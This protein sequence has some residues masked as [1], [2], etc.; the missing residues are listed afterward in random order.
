M[1]KFKF[2]NS[3]QAIPEDRDGNLPAQFTITAA[4][5]TDIWAKPPSTTRFNAP[6]LCQS[7]PLASFKRARLSFNANWKDQYDQG[8]LILIL[9]SVDGKQK[10]VKTGIELTHGKPHVSAVTKDRW[11]DWSLL[12]VPSG[13]RAATME[14]VREKD[15]SLWIYLI[16]GVQ[17]SPIREVS[18]VFEEEGV[19]DCLVGVYVAKPSSEG[20]ELAVNF[21]HVIIDRDD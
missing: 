16:E 19:Q 2:L 3:T 11:A 15:N 5:S 6:I 12:P 4:P 20:E 10:W 7:V 21:G 14:M 13:G 1:T 17:K 9:N 8:G 18:W